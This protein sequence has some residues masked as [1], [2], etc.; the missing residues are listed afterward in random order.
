MELVTGRGDDVVTFIP[1]TS[2]FDVWRDK[3]GTDTLA[4]FDSYLWW[5]TGLSHDG[6]ALLLTLGA[7]LLMPDDPPGTPSIEYLRYLV[8]VA[9]GDSGS[10]ILATLRIVTDLTTLA[11]ADIAVAGT[12]DDDRIIAPLLAAPVSGFSEIFGNDGDDLIRL[13]TMQT[14]RAY[15]GMGHDD[16]R[17]RGVTDDMISG[18]NGRDLLLGRGGDDEIHGGRGGDLIRGGDGDDWLYGDGIG[19]PPRPGYADRILGGAGD[20]YIFGG[21]GGDRLTGGSGA[22]NFEFFLPLQVDNALDHIT[23]FD[24]GAD[25]LTLD[26]DTRPGRLRVLDQDG[27]TL[28][29]YVIQEHGEA[30]RVDIV[31]LEGVSLSRAEIDIFLM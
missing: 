2:D 16:I 31:L 11:G 7:S 22:D 8:P 4:L 1:W 24:A 14:Y 9:D 21:G 17:G 25:W 26:V 15:G 12:P 29:R 20:D 6:S 23:D 10:G 3:G 18:G 28:I 5:D 30:H 27:D 19:Y 13:S